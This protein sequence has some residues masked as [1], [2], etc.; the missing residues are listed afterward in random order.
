MPSFKLPELGIQKM[1]YKV[2]QA[3]FSTILLS[4]SQ[5]K[6]RLCMRSFDSLTYLNLLFLIWKLFDG[7]SQLF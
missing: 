5:T 7:I 3:V 1:P 6:W 2:K 4:K